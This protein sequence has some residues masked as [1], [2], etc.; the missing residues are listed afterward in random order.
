MKTVI[1]IL[2]V[3]SSEILFSQ[4]INCAEKLKQLSSNISNKEYKQANEILSQIKLK[5]ASNSEDIYLLGIEVLQ[6]NIEFAASDK[7]E[8]EIRELIKFYDLYDK[9]FPLNNNGNLISKAMLLY[10][11]N[12]VKDDEAY[13]SFDK[14]FAKDKFQYKNPNALF[15]YFKLFK[16][17]YNDK[18][19]SISFDNLLN[20]YSQVIE[21][22]EKNSVDFPEKKV[23]FDNAI[24]A[25]NSLVK[26]DFNKENIISYS[27]NNFESNKENP[28]WLS[29]TATL[30]SEIAPNSKI[31]GTIANKSHTL[32][33]TSKS[34][35]HIAN[36]NL[37]N[38]NREK[39]LEYLSL[40]ATLATDKLE[41]ASIYYTLATI[42]AQDNKA[43]SKEMLQLAMQNNPANGEY[44]MF[45]VNLYSN[46]NECATTEIEKKA[47]K[48]LVYLTAQKAALKEPKYK[49]T[50]SIFEKET[51]KNAPTKEELN[52]LKKFNNKVLIN[53]WINETVQF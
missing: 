36:Y 11:N 35:Y 20:R 38:R 8:N 43:K 29:S 14:A 6:N 33:P 19:N 3:F 2:L 48:R 17:K 40:S 7:K 28:L 24:L 22:I 47:I 9:N 27:E 1:L 26:D 49:A 10:E 31:F 41:K 45:L 30:L 37:K 5:C 52:S 50:E 34:A 13:L 39:A 51:Q 4:E 21:V 32:N 12:I 44:D 23:E 15:T 25:V 42:L 18:K 46:S 53:C 16:E